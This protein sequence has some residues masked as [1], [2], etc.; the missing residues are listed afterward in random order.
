MAGLRVAE[1]ETLFTANVDAVNKAVKTVQDSGKKVESKPI[2]AKLDG[3]ASDALAAM[4]RVEGAAKKI[5]S[6]ETVAKVDANIEKAESGI[7]RV[8]S[9]LDYLRSVATD[10][11]VQADI[12]KAEANLQRLER[13]RDALVSART[14]IDVIADTSQAERSLADVEGVAGD[15]GGDAGDEFGANMVAALA[16]IP[17][18]GAVIG[19]GVAA[20][21]A[22]L[23]GFKEGLAQEQGRDRL[24]A[25]TGLDEADAARFA[26]AAAESY[27]NVFGESIEANM[28]TMR[29]ALQF[30]LLD[31]D[32]TT[33]HAQKVVQGLAGIADVLGEDIQ[34]VASTVATLLS[35]GIARSAEEAYDL[36]ATGAR[37][38]LNRNEDLLDTLTEYPAL[39]RRLGLDGP[40]AL[41]LM[42]QALGA[43][44][45]NTDLAADALKEF[46]IRATDAS[47]TSAE[48]YRI[49][50][51]SASRMT[52][53]IAA[54][55]E[56]AREG[57]DVVL[58]RLRDMED[59]V[60]RNA[61]AVA[62]FGTQAEDLGEALFAM[63]L[64][65]AVEGLN[66]VEGAAQRMFDTLASNDATSIESAQR[67]I[68]VA[69]DGIKGA[70]AAAFSEPLGD[71]ADWVSQNRGPLTEFLLSLA[72]GA[73]D[74]GR[75]MVTSVAD[76]TVALG[77]FVA[78]PLKETLVGL[79]GFIEMLPGEADLTGIDSLIASMDGFDESTA[80]TA[81]TMRDT[82][83]PG[84]D[85]AQ[86]RMHEWADPIVQMGYLNDA[87]LRAAGAVDAIGLA[88]DGTS[89]LLDALTV[90]HDG[91]V[92][93]SSELD[94][95]LRSAAEALQAELE[96]A[97]AAGE[98]QDQLRTRFDN[99]TA[100]MVD[101]LTAMGLT[102]DQA[103]D[104]I[105][106]YGAVPD[107]V[108]TVITASTL[109]AS[110]D[111]QGFITRW[112]G[113]Q[114]RI[115]VGTYGGETYRVAG[116][117][118]KY[119]HDG[120]LLEFMAHG[121]VRGL[122]PMQP[123]AQMVQPNTWRVVGDR[124]DVAE[125]YIP[126][127]GSARSRAILAETIRRMGGMPMADGGVIDRSAGGG[128]AAREVH[129]HFHIADFPL[130]AV[131]EVARQALA[132][133]LRS[134]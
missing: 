108:N 33:A 95:Q 67:S 104:L 23:D 82:L 85:E 117:N 9:Q 6:A 93:A 14:K 16:S 65:S 57:L 61:A 89:P 105:E 53:E 92:N 4:D 121:G 80:T 18:A 130:G 74:F 116:T 75:S 56:S 109:A 125:A 32:A 36:I 50:G 90:A 129:Q 99:A 40:Q 72:S 25:L 132:D 97:Q 111:I 102:E 76:G 127:D 119:E 98:G 10:L 37:E 107:S 124:S 87:A 3:D 73:L 91:T 8:E 44:A 27:A 22:L 78:G 84:I 70:L 30:D 13:Q 55:G 64:T 58:D 60:K 110:R 96:A 131:R 83:I 49:L 113:K 45:R 134:A 115:G 11:E 46:Q 43:G 118:L 71:F 15:A 31:A 48:G 12:V 122:S 19:V 21:G 86:A 5:V 79:R 66:G 133:Q 1:L 100:G 26:R 42:S 101:Q 103:R 69:A 39:F 34:P 28:D 41:G 114:I 77:Q 51:L 17:I 68:E 24:Q 52:R 29:L 7:S 54:G 88:A 59:P 47:T 94:G 62:L 20:A 38:G 106:T 35:T 120:G 63:D 123:L 2:T 128:T 81:Q 112:D 126:L